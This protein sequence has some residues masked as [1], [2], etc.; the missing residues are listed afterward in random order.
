M[1]LD[2]GTAIV[3]TVQFAIGLGFYRLGQYVSQRIKTR[4]P[5]ILLSW[6]CYVISFIFL[7]SAVAMIYWNMFGPIVIWVANFLNLK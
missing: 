3:S 6:P 4:G 5:R 7:T 2:F 1:E